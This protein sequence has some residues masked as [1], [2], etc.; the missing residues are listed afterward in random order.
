MTPSRINV[1]VGET[2][3][4]KSRLL[5]GLTAR[6]DRLIVLDT[7]SEHADIAAPV[8][9]KTLYHAAQGREPYR[10][11]IYP[12]DA[13]LEWACDLAA[14]KVGTCLAVDE[15]S[16]WWTQPQTV[17][18]EGMLAIVRCGRKVNQSLALVSQSPRVIYG[19]VMSQAALW[20]FP[21][22]LWRDC[23]YILDRTRGKLNPATIPPL[24]KA[25]GRA[26][27]ACWASRKLTWHYVRLRDGAVFLREKP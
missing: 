11:S 12:S 4:G 14:S 1:I 16:F 8:T 23:E 27:V 18:P 15:Y 10:L 22:D 25:I 20:V 19:H 9:A 21:M 3:T 5:R 26:T 13:E 17:P 2:G 7:M 24:D 6:A